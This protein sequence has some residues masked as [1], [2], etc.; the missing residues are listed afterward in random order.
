MCQSRKFIK[1][2]E[3]RRVKFICHLLKNKTEFLT[4]II[5]GKVIGMKGQRTILKQINKYF[6]IKGAVLDRKK[7]LPLQ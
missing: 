5:E 2:L 4:N 3:I 7:W 6:D 1:A